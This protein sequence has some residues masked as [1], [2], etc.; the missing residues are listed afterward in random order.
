MAPLT[1]NEIKTRAVA[2][3]KEWANEGYEAGES[4]SFL[5]DF[6]SVF[7][8]TRRRFVRYERP[9]QTEDGRTGIIDSIWKGVI[10]VEM[11]S[12]GRSLDKAY[13]QAR[14]YLFGLSESELPRYV[15]VSDFQNFRLYDLDEN[16]QWDFPLRDLVK[17][18]KLFG[19][20]AGYQHTDVKEQDPVNIR[21]AE[22]M[23]K[24]HDEMKAIGYDGHQLELYLVRILFCLFA[25]DT[26]LFNKNQFFDYVSQS[27]EDG[28]DLAMRLGMLFEVLN[29]PIDRRLKTFPED[30][31]AFPYVNG[32]LF[33]EQLP[34]SGFTS[35]MR[36]HL[37]SCCRVDWGTVSPAI[38]GSMFQSVMNLEER[39]ALG[40][41][42]TSE[43]NIH[44]VINPLFLDDLKAEF[45]NCKG[46]KRRLEV[47]HNKL[48]SLKF[49][50][51]IMQRLIQ[52]N[53]C[54]RSLQLAG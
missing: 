33:A 26:T 21:A 6:F 52:F 17:R 47:F 8:I 11:K 19:F 3:S 7:G 14:G 16:L 44:K 42:Y 48:A 50:E 31:L 53:D 24:I 20:L 2:F 1:W 51:I 39:R 23:G 43:E 34:V 37:L 30:V 46:N 10:L 15:L 54:R 29:T 28:F 45:E 27:R 41:H 18:V 35:Q 12:L 32:Q 49:L 25:D 5:D 40:A 22:E 38:F 9:V 4:K 36:Q 13:D